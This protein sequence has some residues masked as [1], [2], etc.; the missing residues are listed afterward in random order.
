M[1]KYIITNSI[2][3]MISV[4]Y[5]KM[6][7]KVG[8]HGYAIV[9]GMIAASDENKVI[10]SV[11]TNEFASFYTQENAILWCDFECGYK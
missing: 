2:V 7:K 10:R 11:L 8:E 5:F 9:K 1:E 6:H 4:I 3:K